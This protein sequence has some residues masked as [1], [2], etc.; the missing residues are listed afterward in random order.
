ML[1]KHVS[2]DSSV[3]E[4]GNAY[5]QVLFVMEIKIATMK[6]MKL[7]VAKVTFF[8]I[9]Q[10]YF[11]W[12]RYIFLCYES[13]PSSIRELCAKNYVYTICYYTFLKEKQ[14]NAWR[15]CLKIVWISGTCLSKSLTCVDGKCILPGW[16]CDGE[17][18]CIDGADERNCKIYFNQMN[19]QMWSSFKLPV[20]FHHLI[21]TAW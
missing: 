18:D 10:S 7:I 4:R 9:I 15:K 8:T 20:N 14:L 16:R 11:Q 19:N 6:V 5:N 3:V 17:N 13:F 21:C 1:Q 12:H 2:K